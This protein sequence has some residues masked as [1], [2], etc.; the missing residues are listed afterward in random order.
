MEMNITYASQSVFRILGYTPEEMLTINVSD[1]YSQENF[2]KIQNILIEEL[3][4]GMPHKRVVFQ[5][6][7]FRF[8][9]A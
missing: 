2:R 7:F 9:G 6:R 4:K 5:I 1:L 3:S 8:L